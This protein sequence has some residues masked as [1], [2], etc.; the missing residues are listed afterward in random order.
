MCLQW[1]GT[2]EG[3]AH[4]TCLEAGPLGGR[5]AD[6]FLKTNFRRV[7][8]HPQIIAFKQLPNFTLFGPKTASNFPCVCLRI[9]MS[10]QCVCVCVHTLVWSIYSAVSV[11]FVSFFWDELCVSVGWSLHL[12]SSLC[13][14]CP[15]HK[16]LIKTVG[17]DEDIK[18]DND[19][20]DCP[21][22]AI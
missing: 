8:P 7:F 9:Y 2:P 21:I 16:L 19:L 17:K 22:K 15:Q 10:K 12:S 4:L 5:P 13:N 18:V 20:V 14:I 11:I 1:Q 6:I 3:A